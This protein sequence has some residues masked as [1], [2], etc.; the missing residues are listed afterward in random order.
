MKRWNG[1]LKARVEMPKVDTFLE[2]V[3]TVC[4]KHGMSIA[5]EDT[6]GGFVIHPYTDWITDWFRG[7]STVGFGEGVTEEVEPVPEVGIASDK[8]L[9]RGIAVKTGKW[10]YGDLTH[11]GPDRFIALKGCYPSIIIPETLEQWTGMSDRFGTRIWIGST[12]KDHSGNFEGSVV[13]QSE[14]GEFKLE[15]D[16]DPK[17][18]F[19]LV[20]T[21]RLVVTGSVHD[22]Y[23]LR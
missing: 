4:R 11:D 16:Y 20:C 21:G 19:E 8:I 12:V 13:V 15:P 6:H 10:I 5:H 17:T 7:A 1:D 14:T 23:T 2:E 18:L 3:L 9:F 22:G